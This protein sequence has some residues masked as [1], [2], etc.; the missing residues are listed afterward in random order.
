M[1]CR[2]IAGRAGEV[3]LSGDR[4]RPRQSMIFRMSLT[5]ATKLPNMIPSVSTADILAFLKAHP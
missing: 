3:P 4:H 2:C 5:P 1:P